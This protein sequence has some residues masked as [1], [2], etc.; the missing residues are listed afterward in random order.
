MPT[1][2]DEKLQNSLEPGETVLWT[3][4]PVPRFWDETS[5][6]GLRFGLLMLLFCTWLGVMIA[7][8][9][10]ADSFW[11]TL[12]FYA[13][14]SLFVALGVWMAFAPWLYHRELERTRYALTTRR[15]IILSRKKKEIELKAYPLGP[16]LLRARHYHQGGGGDL[17]F[18]YEETGKENNKPLQR[19]IGF[20]SLAEIQPVEAMLHKLIYGGA[21]GV[22]AGT[23]CE[24]DLDKDARQYLQTCLLPGENIIWA[25][26]P[27]AKLFRGMRRHFLITG[28]W[29]PF[30][31]GFTW[32]VTKDPASP[33]LAGLGFL[34]PFQIAAVWLLIAPF[35]IYIGRKRS[36]YA[37][38]DKRL[39]IASR[40]KHG[41][42]HCH[43]PVQQVGIR[44]IKLYGDGCADVVFRHKG[45]EI[46]LYELPR[47]SAV[48]EAM[49]RADASAR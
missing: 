11:Y 14:L 40:C 10:G 22:P 28:I 33:V 31:G 23:V 42:R 47:A 45:R 25:G 26:S 20:V 7:V 12:P 41:Y 30:I 46:L 38:S 36:L 15:A 3:G 6:S 19:S 17:V 29:L 1:E 24:A 9:V 4:C 8:F 18:D 44:N 49:R 35:F 43:I 37:I 13:V 27:K 34:L 2:Y 21:E 39:I 32:L 5:V 16:D 48:E